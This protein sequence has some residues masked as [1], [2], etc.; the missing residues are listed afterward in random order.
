MDK[1]QC[2][3]QGEQDGGRAS[4]C[5]RRKMKERTKDH[6]NKILQQLTHWKREERESVGSAMVGALQH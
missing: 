3:S 1:L 6:G 2:I 4:Q 5:E